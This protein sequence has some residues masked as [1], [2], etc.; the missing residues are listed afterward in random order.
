MDGGPGLD[1]VVEAGGD[2]LLPELGQDVRRRHGYLARGVCGHHVEVFEVAAKQAV[3]DGG[4]GG[5]ELDLP[6]LEDQAEQGRAG[7]FGG[8]V[9]GLVVEDEPCLAW[10]GGGEGSGLVSAVFDGD[11]F[12][13]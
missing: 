11:G 3:G 6:R 7:V 10:S 9:A 8:V 12:F 13:G 2:L 5:F 1:G 4:V